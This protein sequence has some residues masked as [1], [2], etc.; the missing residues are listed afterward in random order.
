MKL[1][2]LYQKG[3]KL[4]GWFRMKFIYLNFSYLL[5]IKNRHKLA[6]IISALHLC[7]KQMIVLRGYSESE[8]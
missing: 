5:I 2:Y 1:F 8:S 7:G 3:E 4:F 6:R